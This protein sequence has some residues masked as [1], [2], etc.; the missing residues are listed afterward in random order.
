MAYQ[1]SGVTERRYIQ[2]RIDAIR[3]CKILGLVN[4]S[5]ETAAENCSTN[6]I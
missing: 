1:S 4:P 3:E 5:D 6:S 2:T